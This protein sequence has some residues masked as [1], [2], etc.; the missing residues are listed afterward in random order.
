MIWATWRIHRAIILVSI[1]IA[2]AFAVWLAATGSSEAH[3]WSIFSSHHCSVDYPGSSAICQSSIDGVNQFS[4][5]NVVLCGALPALLGLAL[6]GPLIAGEIQQGTNRL[7]WT[8][9]ITRTRW[10]IIK[11]VVTAVFIA[12]I[13]GA[14]APLIW[15]YLDAAQRGSH[16]QPSNFDIS[17]FVDVAYALFALALVAL[18]GALIRRTGWAFAAAVPLFVLAR[19]GVR[20]FVRPELVTP[21]TTT[22]NPSGSPPSTIWFLHAGFVSLGRSTPAPG[23][24]W[25][26]TEQIIQNCQGI[27]GGQKPL[28]SNSYCERVNH[29]HYVMQFQPP[30]HF[31]ALQ[32]AESAIFLGIAG[33]LVGLTVLTVR[34]WRT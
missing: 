25:S 15:W 9:S 12:A 4:S 7:A 24:T 14:F 5:I 3:A 11:I 31:W 10:L 17:G 27:S 2:A 34:W 32:A 19:F 26:S 23:Q 29:L 28:H 20:D 6:G 13:V 1:A 8:Q 21:V 30:S 18:A 16:I 33:V 22:A